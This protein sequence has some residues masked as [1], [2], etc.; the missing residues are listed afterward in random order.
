MPYVSYIVRLVNGDPKF[1]FRTKMAKNY[2]SI[3]RESGN[4][5]FILPSPNVLQ[6]LWKVPV[7]ESDLTA[8]KTTQVY[9]MY[10]CNFFLN[11]YLHEAGCSQQA[12]HLSVSG[13]S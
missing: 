11:L 7:V 9:L 6:S 10:H 3:I 13:S 8:K 1:H 12:M 2:V 4:D 5:C